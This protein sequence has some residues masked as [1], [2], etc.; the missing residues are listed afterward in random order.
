MSFCR[1]ITNGDIKTVFRYVEQ[2]DE[3]NKQTSFNK[4][5]KHDDII[6]ITIL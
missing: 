3:I 4:A 5:T 1:N 2:N 6:A